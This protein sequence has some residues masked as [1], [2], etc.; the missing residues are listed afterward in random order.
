MGKAYILC[1]SCK[2]RIKVSSH[3]FCDTDVSIGL[4]SA[5]MMCLQFTNAIYVIIWQFGV[6]ILNYFDDLTGA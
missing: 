5:A 2:Y 6:A 1:Q 4:R 3:I